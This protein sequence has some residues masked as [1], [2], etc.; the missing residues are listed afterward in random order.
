[1]IALIFFPLSYMFLKQFILILLSYI[2]TPCSGN[3]C[4]NNGTCTVTGSGSTYFCMCANG[5]SGTNCEGNLTRITFV[6]N[7]FIFNDF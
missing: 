1:M 2:V 5:F 3:P 6:S 4:M 7:I